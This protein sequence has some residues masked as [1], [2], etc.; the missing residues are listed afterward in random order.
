MEKL[1]IKQM[2]DWGMNIQSPVIIAGPCSA[3]SEE[4]VM[5]TAEQLANKNV[6]IFRSGIWKPRT[7]PNTFEGVGSI[8][9]K[10]LKKVKEKYGMPITVE[11]ANKNH[12]ENALKEG[13]DILWI[14]ARTTVNP[15]AIQEIAD[16]LQGVDIPVMVK[17]PINPDLE[18]WIGA[19]ERLNKAGITKLAAIHRGFS[20]YGESVFRNV[21]K[22]EIPVELKRRFPNLPIICDPSHIS[23]NRE[24]IPSVSQKSIDLD[25]SGLMIET[26]INPDEAWS[27][28]KQ[29]VTPTALFDILEHLVWRNTSADNEFFKNKLDELRENIDQID[30]NLVDILGNRMKLVKQIAQYKK[31]ND[32]TIL[33]SNRWNDILETRIEKALGMD[34]SEE[35][36]AKLFQLIHQES[37]NKQTEIMNEK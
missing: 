29:Q 18:L 24:L 6:S 36:T 19:M 9:L 8:G 11:I 37:I 15:F 5:Q 1:N 26:H 14:G 12:V 23:G 13:I 3:E 27:D 30:D 21:P 25:L 28:A 32:V 10:W 35:F 22:W 7:R 2:K 33:Q 34:I 4:Q 17:N 16:V 31:E 20:L